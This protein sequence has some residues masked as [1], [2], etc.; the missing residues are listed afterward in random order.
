M[1]ETGKL[2]FIKIQNFRSTK[3]NANIMRRQA[4]DTKYLQKNTSDKG[5]F[6][7]IPKNS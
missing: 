5:L 7:N 1:K 2:D 4:M 6:Q 3:D